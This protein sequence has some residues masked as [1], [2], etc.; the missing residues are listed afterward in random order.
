MGFGIGAPFAHLVRVLA[1]VILHRR[2]RAPI[3]IALAQHRIHRTALDLVV[4]CLDVL[5][6]IVLRLVRVIRQ[7]TTLA[8][9]FPDGRLHLRQRGRNVGQLDDVGFGGER[10]LAELGQV[11]GD[12][13]VGLQRI[14]ELREDASRQ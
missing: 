11:V 3:G 13:L 12:F 6:R 5:F 8:L 2:R 1:R 4:A 14:R 9:Q 10:Q 7:R